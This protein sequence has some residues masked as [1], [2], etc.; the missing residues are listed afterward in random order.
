[1]PRGHFIC[2]ESRTNAESDESCVIDNII[3]ESCKVNEQ[4]FLF[5]VS[6]QAQ[7][8]SSD[9][10]RRQSSENSSSTSVKSTLKEY[11]ESNQPRHGEKD[12]SA[13][14]CVSGSVEMSEAFFHQS[15]R[16]LHES[17][18]IVLYDTLNKWWSAAFYLV[19]E[20]RVWPLHTTEERTEMFSYDV[21]E[22]T[23]SFHAAF[24]LILTFY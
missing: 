12:F 4:F 24:Q 22:Q 1:M 20:G 8:W 16:H 7:S 10:Q 11:E 6:C 13:N 17:A 18:L 14:G 5:T 15:S 19:S 23:L 21:N 2:F 9:S 3:A